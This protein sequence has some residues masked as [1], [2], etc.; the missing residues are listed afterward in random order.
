MSSAKSIGASRRSMLPRCQPGASRYRPVPSPIL[1]AGR[2]G[3]RQRGCPAHRQ[4]LEA[5]ANDP[6]PRHPLATVS[7]HI[8]PRALN[9]SAGFFLCVILE[10]PDALGFS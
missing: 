2:P 5:P 10:N 6:G 9:G 4:A 1:A 8:P 7:G 3:G